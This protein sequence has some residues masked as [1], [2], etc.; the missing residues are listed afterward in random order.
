MA[1]SGRAPIALPRNPQGVLELREL[2]GTDDLLSDTPPQLSAH[3]AITLGPYTL[4]VDRG[5]GAT[6]LRISV[7]ACLTIR[8]STR[9]V[10]PVERKLALAGCTKVSTWILLF[11]AVQA[12]AGWQSS[13]AVTQPGPARSQESATPASVAI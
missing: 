8:T 4:T 3:G 7:N 11:C 6:E 9:H 12:P 10:G 1:G 5:D 2:P 13:R